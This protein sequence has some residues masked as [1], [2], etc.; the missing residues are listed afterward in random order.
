MPRP[1]PNPK[2]ETARR[3]LGE[4]AR[5]LGLIRRA[6][7]IMRAG[8]SLNIAARRLRA[9][10]ANLSRYFTAF[11]AGGVA[12]LVPV[13][14][15]GRPSAIAKLAITT[16]EIRSIAALARRGN[17]TV[18]CREFAALPGTRP[19]LAAA[20]SSRIPSSVVKAIRAA[21]PKPDAP[22]WDAIWK[23]IDDARA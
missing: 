21:L 17:V 7:A 20:L 23:R 22:P 12:A 1:K 6:D 2:I 5:R 16:D 4:V 11:R 18:A 13:A 3:Q 8:G 14:G 15:S 9:P 10:I 19:E